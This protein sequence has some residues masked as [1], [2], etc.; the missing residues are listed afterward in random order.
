MK[1]L[2]ECQVGDYVR[3]WCIG[4]NAFD[5]EVVKIISIGILVEV[6]YKSG[7]KG[8]FSYSTECEVINF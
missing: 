5:N 2:E 1:K 3:L 8:N 4:W 6:Q 7:A